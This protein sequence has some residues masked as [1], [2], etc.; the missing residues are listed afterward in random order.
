MRHQELNKSSLDYLFSKKSDYLV[1]DL[2]NNRLDIHK[3]GNRSFPI[4]NLYRKNKDCYEDIL[5]LHDYEIIH[6]EDL[7]FEDFVPG[8]DKLCKLVLE[9]YTP[10]Q[11][12]VNII[13]ASVFFTNGISKRKFSDVIVKHTKCFN[14]LIK[15]MYDYI[16]PRLKGCHV[17]YPPD[18]V[19]A[20]SAHKWGLHPLHFHDFYYEYAARAIELICKN[21]SYHEE[22]AQLEE[23][24]QLYSEKFEFLNLK[25][26]MS[27]KDETL[28]WRNNAMQF[29]KELLFDYIADR[30]FAQN[31]QKLKDRDYKV[32]ILKAS[33]IAGEI[34]LKALE[35]N[36]IEV[37]FKTHLGGFKQL[38]PED[39]KKCEN[40]DLVIIAN[41]HDLSIGGGASN[42]RVINIRDLLK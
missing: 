1:I 15:E 29:E 4:T 19:I 42:I 3:S 5:G 41:V 24:R 31:L 26:N 17:I 20:S 10:N 39:L 32:S 25:L 35:K 36:G 11:V 7:C 38:S 16:V 2:M 27:K 23:L 37:V 14:Q 18:N 13:E 6:I 22:T 28:K 9:H 33:D 12:I 8:L 34:L 21:L 30:K 40:S